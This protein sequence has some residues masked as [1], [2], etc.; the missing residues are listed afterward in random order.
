MVD[1]MEIPEPRYAKAADGV[2]LAYQVFG[3]G[4]H[5]IVWLPG[6]ATQL[7]LA[8]DYRPSAAFMLGLA[9]LGRVILVDRR[10][11][12][13]SDRVPPDDLPP[14]EV[15][16][17]DLITVLDTVGSR[18]TA[19]FGCDEGAHAGV[20][21]AAT[22]PE[23]VRA[24]VLFAPRPSMVATPEH[25][26]GGSR[27]EW[28]EWLEWAS[29]NWG[30][31]E[32]IVHD[33]HELAP[34]LLLDEEAIRWG[35]RVQR[36][37]ASPSAAVALFR[38]S[39]Q[40]NVADVLPT[41][42]TPTLIVHRRDDVLVPIEAGRA[43]ADLMPDATF[44]EL[45]GQEHFASFGPTTEL[46]DAIGSFLAS[47]TSIVADRSRR[48]ATILFTDIVSSTERAAALGDREGGP[49]PRPGSPRG[50]PHGRGR[51]RRGNRDR[52]RSRDRREDRWAGRRIR[53]PGVFDR[54]GPHRRV[55]PRVRGCGRA[56]TQGCA[57]PVACVSRG[58]RG[59][60]LLTV[61]SRR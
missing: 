23:R 43:V 25:P 35:A 26:W 24:L 46:L 32:S 31:R 21:L 7:D 2:S 30:S 44:V 55:G 11:V 48:L 5:D 53:G 27:E 29:V 4:R 28:E 19:A 54:K 9:E 14:V 36:S 22:H 52:D 33:L 57:G 20:L 56:S 58:V 37:A 38:I 1:R 12:G 41:V 10:G 47:G 39:M 61:P 34:S 60:S 50:R 17:S 42:R 40:L 18:D 6:N 45:P 13:L 49:G 8:W 15:T 51:D 3:H 59:R 16:V